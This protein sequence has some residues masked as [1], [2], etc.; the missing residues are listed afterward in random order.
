MDRTE[1]REQ[2]FA[3]AKADP[4]THMLLEQAARAWVY[5][6]EQALRD[7]GLTEMRLRKSYDERHREALAWLTDA[8]RDSEAKTII[9]MAALGDRLDAAT[10]R[11]P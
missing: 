9:A 10:A 5:G 3:E 11:E 7:A 2:F 4:Y 6:Y 1:L 8:R